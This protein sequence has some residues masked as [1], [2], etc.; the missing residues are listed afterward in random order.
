MTDAE[1]DQLF[2]TELPIL[3]PGAALER[4][5]LSRYSRMRAADL[6][7]APPR[8]AWPV[9]IGAAA[10]AAGLVLALQPSVPEVGDPAEMVARG[11]GDAVPTLVLELALKE[12]GRRL[13]VGESLPVGTTLIFRISVDQPVDYKL[14]RQD[15]LIHQGHL[16]PG[17]K[18]LPI[19]YTLEAGEGPTVFRLQAG[20]QEV[21]VPV[22]GVQP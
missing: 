19:G 8:W 21:R 6:R 15:Q 12:E 10:M 22:G 14:Y 7:P 9:G 5:V 1:L 4:Q 3:E 2:R 18:V 13:R 11:A 16:E 17:E 20:G